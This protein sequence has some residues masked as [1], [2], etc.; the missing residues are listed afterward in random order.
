[1]KLTTD[2]YLF[3]C[4][5]CKNLQYA[6]FFKRHNLGNEFHEKCPRCSDKN[7]L[8]RKHII[9]GSMPKIYKPKQEN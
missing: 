2:Y 8:Y 1:M 9:I 7:A 6:R 3:Q 4:T 5:N